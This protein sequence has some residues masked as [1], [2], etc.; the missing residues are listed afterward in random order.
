MTKLEK[1]ESLREFAS[2]NYEEISEKIIEGLK[3]AE[4]EWSGWQILVTVDLDTHELGISG[5][6]SNNSYFASDDIYT[7]ASCGTW[8]L[9]DYEGDFLTSLENLDEWEELK[10]KYTSAENYYGDYSDIYEFIS[11]E[12]SEIIDKIDNENREGII[13]EYFP[14]MAENKYDEFLGNL[15]VDILNAKEL[16]RCI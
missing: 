6:M 2:N 12:H 10:T 15:D 5:L 1:L 7:I 4:H 9:S 16:Q 3:E 14:Q 13:E 11:N 8:K